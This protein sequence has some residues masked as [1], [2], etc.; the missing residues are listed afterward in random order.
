MDLADFSSDYFVARDRFRA[1]IDR[2]SGKIEAFPLGGRPD[3]TMDVAIFG[4]LDPK[5]VLIVSSG[6]HGVEGPFGSAVQ[7]SWLEGWSGALPN[8]LAVLFLHALNP[9]GFVNIRRFD[10]SNIDLNRNF[11]LKGQSYQGSPPSYTAVDSFLNPKSP[12]TFFD[13][14]WF[15]TFRAILRHGFQALKQ[16]VAGGQCD[17]PL[18]LFYGGSGP[19]PLQRL[20]TEKLPEWM[21][22]AERSIHL[23]YHTGLGPRG[24]YKLMIDHLIPPGR[25]ESLESFFTDG[26]ISP[27]Q[28]E[29]EAYETRGSIGR[30]FYERL[31]RC[32]YNYFCAEFGTEPS[33]LMIKALRAENRAY[34]W[35]DPESDSTRRTKARLL[36]A[37][38][39]ADRNWR[40]QTVGQGVK[41]ID[42]GIGALSS[43]NH[44]K[45]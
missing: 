44:T 18:G 14:F 5:Q 3:L 42:Q 22:S 43:Q 1:A 31:D 25:F 35:G 33:I 26:G 38:V 39:P 17:F 36:E 12:P 7:S 37:F 32:N 28:E 9:Y 13:P 34:H 4:D 29:K 40:Q 6:L 10:E 8:G 45:E 27:F 23:D 24:T 19:A 11:L 20:L 30:W 16:A 21:R 2:H 15:L 41:F